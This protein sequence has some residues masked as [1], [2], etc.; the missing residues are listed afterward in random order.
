MLLALSAGALISLREAATARMMLWMSLTYGAGLA[1][2][3]LWNVLAARPVP[4]SYVVVFGLI[5]LG[6][7]VLLWIERGRIAVR[8]ELAA[9]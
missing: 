5:A 1:L 7:A 4:W 8:P 3:S 9:R 2:A 6:S